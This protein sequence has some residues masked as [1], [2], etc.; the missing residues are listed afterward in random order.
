MVTRCV[1]P[2]A[3]SASCGRYCAA[4]GST[5][6]DARS[7]GLCAASAGT[8]TRPAVRMSKPAASVGPMREASRAIEGRE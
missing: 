3:S 8:S 6:S 1:A 5:V 4:S 7:V 2:P